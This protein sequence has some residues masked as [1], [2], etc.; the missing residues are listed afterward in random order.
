MG[1]KKSTEDKKKRDMGAPGTLETVSPTVEGS[2][3]NRHTGSGA[4][5]GKSQSETL[6]QSEKSLGEKY[7]D[8]RENL[9]SDTLRYNTLVNVKAPVV[10]TTNW[11][12]LIS[13][14][15]VA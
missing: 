2:S 7:R 15:V 14:L 12:W 1:R 6:S 13:A 11:W 5:V 8:N 10:A 9:L 3:D 4:S